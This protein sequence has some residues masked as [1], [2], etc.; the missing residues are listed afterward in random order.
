MN[1]KSIILT[2]A[3]L[4]I[5]LSLVKLL[6]IYLFDLNAWYMATLFLLAT[7]LVTTGV[8]RRAGIINNFEVIILIVFWTVLI[9]LWDFIVLGK[10]LGYDM[11]H[12]LYFWLGYVM[13]L[14]AIVVFHKWAP[15]DKG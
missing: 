2:T 5:C 6:F 12:H 8:V 9:L 10:F 11:Y 13:M 4:L 1:A 3:G 15:F 14:F 7:L